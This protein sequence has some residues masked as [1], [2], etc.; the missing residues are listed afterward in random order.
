[1]VIVQRGLGRR[2]LIQC[3]GSGSACL[4]AGPRLEEESKLAAFGPYAKTT[5]LRFLAFVRPARAVHGDFWM[6]PA[7]QTLS[8]PGEEFDRAL[9]PGSQA[10]L[11]ERT[12]P[13][14]TGARHPACRTAG[15]PRF[16]GFADGDVECR[17]VPGGYPLYAHRQQGEV[18]GPAARLRSS[19]LLPPSARTDL[20]PIER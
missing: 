1:M 6:G 9:D 20:E 14:G 8:V 18:A 3:P 16:S 15:L 12:A 11:A 17:F 13:G 10:A 19:H 7:V 2:H 5:P 4:Q